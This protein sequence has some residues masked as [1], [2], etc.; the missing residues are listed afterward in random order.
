MTNAIARP[1]ISPARH[2]VLDYGVA[3]TFFAL[4]YRYRRRN[5]AASALALT[6][7]ARR[8]PALARTSSVS[9]TGPKPARSICRR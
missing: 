4:A 6:N 8:W 2:A 9:T 5:R 1:P 7:G 3:A